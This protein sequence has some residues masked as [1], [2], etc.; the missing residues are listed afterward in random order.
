MNLAEAPRDCIVIASPA[1]GTESASVRRKW[2]EEIR[3]YLSGPETWQAARDEASVIETVAPEPSPVEAALKY[4]RIARSS[5]EAYEGFSRAIGALAD[6]DLEATWPRLMAYLTEPKEPYRPLL[7]SCLADHEVEL[8]SPWVVRRIAEVLSSS[9]RDLARSA[10]LA[11]LAGGELSSNKLQDELARLH[12]ARRDDLQ[13]LV[14][15]IDGL[16]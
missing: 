6:G 3:P 11:L 13:R 12:P 8:S 16:K 10:A 5:R 15:L 7:L 9:D 4:A 1:V 2:R 14:G